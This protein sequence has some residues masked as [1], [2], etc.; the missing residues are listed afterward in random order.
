MSRREKR[1]ESLKRSRKG[2]RPQD[3]EGIILD[4][5]FVKGSGKGDHRVYRHPDGRHFTLDFGRNPVR[6]VYVEQFLALIGEL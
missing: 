1:L 2:V 3:F 5:G 6:R 4:F